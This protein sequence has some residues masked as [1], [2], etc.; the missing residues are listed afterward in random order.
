MST[1]TKPQKYKIQD[2]LNVINA[3]LWTNTEKCK[4]SA[5]CYNELLW[6]HEKQWQFCSHSIDH[7][8][9]IQQTVI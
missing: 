9:F 5:P 7:A 6:S 4:I 2:V 1:S 3:N 8:V